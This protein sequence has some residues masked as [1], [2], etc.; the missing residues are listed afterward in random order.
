MGLSPQKGSIE[1]GRDA[2]LMI[3]DPAEEKII[4]TELLHQHVD[5]TP[6]AGM[7][8]KGWPKTVMLRGKVL[9][10]NGNLQV[11][12]GYGQYIKRQVQ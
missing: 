5:Y 4:S 11:S 3:L 1:I 12:K 10:R 2:D 7:T 6:F 9:V 8:V